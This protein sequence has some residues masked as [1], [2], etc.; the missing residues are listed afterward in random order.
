MATGGTVPEIYPPGDPRNEEDSVYL[1][2]TPGEHV[3]PKRMGSDVPPP[4]QTAQENPQQGQGQ[5]SQGQGQGGGQSNDS[6]QN[7]IAQAQAAKANQGFNAMGSGAYSAPAGS[8]AMTVGDAA[9]GAAIPNAGQTQ[10]LG[11]LSGGGAAGGAAG[12]ASGLASGLQKAVDAYAQSI[13]PWQMQQQAFGKNGAP[14]YQTT[15]FQ[16]DQTA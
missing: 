4:A 15:N 6:W 3:I 2:A 5:Q 11:Q 8:S 13:K 12:V 7:I 10:N 9:G 1:K 16:Q 14:S